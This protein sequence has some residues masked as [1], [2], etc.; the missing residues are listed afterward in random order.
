MIGPFA[1]WHYVHAS[2]LVGLPALFAN[3]A[4]VY[5]FAVLTRDQRISYAVIVGLLVAYQVAAG[6]LGNMD[7]RMAAALVDPSGIAAISEVMQYW[8]VFERNENVVPIAGTLLINRIL[9]LGIGVLLLAFTV[10]RFNFVLS[11]SKRKKKK[12]GGR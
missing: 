6:L 7:Q 3:S 12:G 5:A 1:L 2:V 9:W 4:I 8:T 10:N 11:K